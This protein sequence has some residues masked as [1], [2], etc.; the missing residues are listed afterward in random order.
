MLQIRIERGVEVTPYGVDL[1]TNN[2]LRKEPRSRREM[3]RLKRMGE[4]LKASGG[5]WSLGGRR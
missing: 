3:Q 5:G 4:R 1:E 2:R